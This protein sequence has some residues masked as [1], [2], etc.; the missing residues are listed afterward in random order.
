MKLCS[1]PEER[2]GS[3]RKTA[4]ALVIWCSASFDF[5][6][7]LVWQQNYSRRVNREHSQAEQVMGAAVWT[8]EQ[9]L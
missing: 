8:V 2:E 9:G 4:V 5:R 1:V 7:L 6:R 3:E